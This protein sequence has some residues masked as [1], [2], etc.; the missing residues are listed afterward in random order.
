MGSYPR[1]WGYPNLG[2]IGRW[3]G[4]CIKWVVSKIKYSIILQK[5]VSNIFFRYPFLRC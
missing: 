1:E 4:D 2:I 5:I 3:E